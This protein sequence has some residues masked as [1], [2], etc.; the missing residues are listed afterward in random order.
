MRREGGSSP[1][2]VLDIRER[3]QFVVR[4]WWAPVVAGPLVV[5]LGVASW[6]YDSPHGPRG[7]HGRSLVSPVSIAVSRS[8]EIFV[9]TDYS[10]IR[11]FDRTG[12]ELRGWRVNAGLGH[13]VLAFDSNGVLHV[14]TVRNDMH[15]AFDAFGRLLEKAEDRTA[16]ER[17]ETIRRS[18]LGPAGQTYRIRGNGVIRSTPGGQAIVVVPPSPRWV[19]LGPLSL[20]LV[21][22]GALAPLAGIALRRMPS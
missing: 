2:R 17:V 20:L 11:V 8:E 13:A 6:W 10:R 12:A 3:T 22:I 1:R 4:Q 5:A 18:A 9:F 14:A 19:V 21:P 7:T 15:Y 16:L